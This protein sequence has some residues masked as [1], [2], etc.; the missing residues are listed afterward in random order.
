MILDLGRQVQLL[1]DIQD[2]C[3]RDLQRRFRYGDTS[4]TMR[5]EN[6]FWTIGDDLENVLT[7]IYEDIR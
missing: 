5:I 1:Q 7:W 4:R 3:W 6:T 2:R